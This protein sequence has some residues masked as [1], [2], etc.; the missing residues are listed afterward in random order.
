V[1]S[2]VPVFEAAIQRK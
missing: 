2:P 1:T